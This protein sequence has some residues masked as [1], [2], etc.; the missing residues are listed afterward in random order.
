MQVIEAVLGVTLRHS[1][2]GLR[3]REAARLAGAL[4]DSPDFDAGYTPE[5][6]IAHDEYADLEELLSS[7]SDANFYVW[8]MLRLAYAERTCN[9]AAF[10]PMQF[11][12]HRRA[13]PLDRR[14]GHWRGGRRDRGAPR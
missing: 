5:P 14:R 10:T 6:L 12:L 9:L 11:R 13:V 3:K 4:L 2:R 8:A 1:Q 7:G